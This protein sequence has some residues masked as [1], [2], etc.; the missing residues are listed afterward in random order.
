[1]VIIIDLPVKD[2]VEK[3]ILTEYLKA[4]WE[5]FLKYYAIPEHKINEK[6]EKEI[7]ERKQT[8]YVKVEDEEDLLGIISG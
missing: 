5:I 6:V 7:R 4:Q 2:E 8:D 1:M 3:K